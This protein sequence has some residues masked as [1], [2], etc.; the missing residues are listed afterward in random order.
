MIL[1][2][3]AILTH[4]MIARWVASP[5]WVPDL[6]LIGLTLAIGRAPERWWSFAILAGLITMPWAAR[7]PAQV[8]LSYLVCGWAVRATGNR[9]DLADLRVQWVVTCLAVGLMRLWACWLENLWSP[10][11]LGL[12]GLQTVLT[13][14]SVPGLRWLL[15]S[16]WNSASI[17]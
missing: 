1:L 7:F 9:W 5:W 8:F 17:G 10:P 16:R 12:A 15:A 13:G 3:S 2:S 11:V 14:L 6:T 4:L